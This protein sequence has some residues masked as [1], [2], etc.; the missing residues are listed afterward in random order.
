[1]FI[2]LILMLM[3]YEL[4]IIYLLLYPFFTVL[5]ISRIVKIGR[6]NI[7]FNISI[8]QQHRNA[9]TPNTSW[10]EKVILRANVIN[11]VWIGIFATSFS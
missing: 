3:Y 11:Y 8:R 1:M 9:F 5:T 4:N 6:T 7:S 2:T 10:V